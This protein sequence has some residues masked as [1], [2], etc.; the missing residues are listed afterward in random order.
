MSQLEG[1]LLGPRVSQVSESQGCVNWIRDTLRLLI[2]WHCEKAYDKEGSV[3]T[4]YNEGLKD[5]KW[6]KYNSERKWGGLAD[7]EKEIKMEGVSE[8]DRVKWER[9]RMEYEEKVAGHSM[10]R[11]TSQLLNYTSPSSSQLILIPITLTTV[12]IDPL[13]LS[14]FYV[15]PSPHLIFF[16]LS[17]PSLSLLFYFSLSP[18]LSL[19]RSPCFYINVSLSLFPSLSTPPL[20][21]RLDMIER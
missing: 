16:H 15:S 1:L 19:F 5:N 6:K 8:T 20:S 14:L 17:I 4:R 9:E 21:S 11:P 13:S 12:N 2:D 7:R 18:S 10:S 3:Q